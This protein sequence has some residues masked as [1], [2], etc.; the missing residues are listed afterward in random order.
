FLMSLIF[1]RHGQTVY[2]LEDKFQGVSDSPLTQSGID[3][4]NRLND[5]L[6]KNFNVKKFLISPLPRV[7]QT[8]EIVSAGLNAE[9]EELEILREVSYG[10]WEEK[11]REELDQDLL[12]ERSKKRFTF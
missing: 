8:Y 5:Y 12:K 7:I 9:V 1:C 2:N 4:A 6:V 3:Q 11:R 10:S